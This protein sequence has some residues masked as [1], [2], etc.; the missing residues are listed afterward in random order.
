MEI[1]ILD[2][3]GSLPLFE[4]FGDL[5]TKIIDEKNFKE[6][7][8]LD[9]LI[10]PGGSLI[11]SKSLTN[12]LKN[13]ILNFDG[14]IIGICSGFQILSNKIDIGR[15][16]NVPIIKEGL[17][18][19]DVNFSPLVCTDRVEFNLKKSIFGEGVGFGFHC[20]TYGNIEIF[21]KRTKILTTSIVKK[22]D[23]KVG[24]SK[25]IISGA[26]KGKIFGTMVHN[27]LDNKFVRDNFLKHLKISDDEKEKIFEKN[28]KIKKELKIR[29]LKNQLTSEINISKNINNTKNRNLERGKNKLN[30]MKGIVLLSTSSN[31]G[32]TFLT[33]ALSAKL[34]G[35]IFVA[36]IGGDVRD[37]VPSLYL[38]R[39]KMTKYNSIKIGN[40]GWVDVE[41]F[42][43][44]VKR[45][46]YNYVIIEGVM[47]AFTASFKN[48]SSYQIVKKL[49]FPV[50]IVSAC[51][52]S[53]MEG[54]FV[55]AVSYYHLLKKIGGVKVEGIILNKIYDLEIFNALKNLA[56]KYGIKLYGVKKV[57]K[58]GRG[59]IP[60]VEID[61]EEFCRSAF[62]IDLDIEIPEIDFNIKQLDNKTFI[63]ELDLWMR[64]LNF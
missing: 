45:E 6:I 52:L 10:I 50:Y 4:D 60:E 47:G 55:E 38:L 9:C 15:K 62:E 59:L 3:K 17:G 2:I 14:H 41:E 7:K 26:F 24:L 21:N 5:P 61:Y 23:Y 19:L 27:F 53:G 30:N 28:R 44:H 57:N 42:L 46:N 49:G 12:E 13:E 54:A 37:I 64:S 36:K 1:G 29:S 31:S 39:E 20:H 16:S 63:E 35:K 22:I 32:K 43:N 33:T 48:M 56:K 18:L 25:E 58:E 34:K 8:D 11:E 51:N 40:R